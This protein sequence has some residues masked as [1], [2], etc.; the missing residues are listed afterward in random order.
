[1]CRAG[2]SQQSTL[3]VVLTYL[4]PICFLVTVLTLW[5]LTF[6]ALSCSTGYRH[7]MGDTTCGVISLESLVS[8]G[9][10]MTC[11]ISHDFCR[12]LP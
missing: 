3:S 5:F 9:Y 6:G 8:L 10:P 12:A 11:K 4:G 2:H 1:M 7:T